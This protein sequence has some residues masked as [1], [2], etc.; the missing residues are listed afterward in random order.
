MRIERVLQGSHY[1]HIGWSCGE[2]DWVPGIDA[3]DVAAAIV[4]AARTQPGVCVPVLHSWPDPTSDAVRLVI[5][6]LRDSMTF[7][8]LD[9]T[10]SPPRA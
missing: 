6:T 9:Q 4:A 10:S 1:Q 7:V 8:R 2:N 5:E 3:G